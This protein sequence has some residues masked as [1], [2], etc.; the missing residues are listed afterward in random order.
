MQNAKAVFFGAL[1]VVF[2]AGGRLYSAEEKPAPDSNQKLQM[3]RELQALSMSLKAENSPESAQKARDLERMIAELSKELTPPTPSPSPDD[4]N[5][6]AAPGEP[7]SELLQAQLAKAEQ[8]IVK[9]EQKLAELSQQ[10]AKL[11]RQNSLPPLPNAEV[12]VFTLNK[13][14][15]AEAARTIESLFGAQTL[16]VATDDRTNS[17]IVLG[18]PDSL[19]AVEALLGRMDQQN[20]AGP[21]DVH[22]PINPPRS[23]LLRI[24]WLA[25]GL[26]TDEYQNPDEFLP[27]SVLKAVDRLG[28]TN[29]RLVTQTV[30]SLAVA[31]D[32]SVEYG[33]NVPAIVFNQPSNLNCA[34]HMRW[35][36]T[37]NSVN[38]DTQVN[39]MGQAVNCQ[40]SGSLFMPL[41]HYMVL[42]TAN[43]V[44][45]DQAMAAA[46]VNANGAMMGRG[47]PEG[48]GMM[49]H[50]APGR[51]GRAGPGAGDHGAA[52]LIVVRVG[53]AGPEAVP[54][55]EGVAATTRRVNE[56]KYNTSHF[57]FVVQVIEAESFAPEAQSDAKEAHPKA[58]KK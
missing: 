36:P 15:A 55:L 45:A 44:I 28:I 20:S 49:G 3:V 13:S 35:S 37:D 7:K 34:G 43:S 10:M 27:K 17:L 8:E 32:Q 53:A 25:D 19:T 9:R 57:A 11:E 42:G 30:N 46:E 4:A 54:A 5:W 16:R 2:V 51:L 29:P 31:E 14:A 21:A 18:A 50:E 33:I 47:G 48:M 1:F 56:A 22:P 23:L 40:L 26:P 12:K 39:V 38:L 24:F 58:A 52:P 41:E 6:N